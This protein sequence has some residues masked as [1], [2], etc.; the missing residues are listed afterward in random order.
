MDAL[1]GMLFAFAGFLYASIGFTLSVLSTFL[2]LF[3]PHHPTGAEVASTIRRRR[4]RESRHKR[5]HTSSTTDSSIFSHASTSSSESS[6]T[7]S[8]MNTRKPR[9]LEPKVTSEHVD[10]PEFPNTVVL[11]R[12]RS[13]STP[14]SPSPW[15]ISHS[16]TKRSADDTVMNTR[17]RPS[18]FHLP[19]G[20]SFDFSL[21]NAPTG[22]SFLH[23]RKSRTPSSFSGSLA[24][25]PVIEKKKSQL[26]GPLLHR[27]RSQHES[28]MSKRSS[29]ISM[30]PST[31]EDVG[32]SPDTPDRRQSL[33]LSAHRLPPKRSQTLRTQP[34][35]APYFFPTPGSAE[36]ESYLPP[37][38]Q[39]ARP[40]SSGTLLA[41]PS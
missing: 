21:D 32:S 8:E 9:S 38:R 41:V 33:D 18:S 6:S 39:L 19:R 24:S 3:F 36:A 40:P 20:A 28:D 37:R 35:E 25:L 16:D 34:Y 12:R 17:E 5:R 31:E 22:L 15:D 29:L 14:P 27:R 26:F 10:R 1:R 2:R 11:R 30:S 4:T 23:R 13:E 7:T